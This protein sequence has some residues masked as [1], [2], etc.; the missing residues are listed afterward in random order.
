MIKNISRSLALSAGVT[1]AF[2]LSSAGAWQAS[3]LESQ[4][5][6]D[7]EFAKDA[8]KYQRLVDRYCVSCHNKEMDTAQFVLENEGLSDIKQNG[9]IWEKVIHKLRVGEMPPAEA[10]QPS[11]GAKSALLGW[12]QDTLND[13]AVSNP[14]PGRPSVHRLNRTEYQNAIRDLLDLEIDSKSLLPTDTADFGFDNIGSSL[15]TSPLYLE[16]YMMAASKVSRLAIGDP[17]VKES[18]TKYTIPKLKLQNDRMNEDLSFGSR[19]GTSV[20]HH[21]PLDAD[22]VIKV[23]IESPRSD[24]PQDLFQRSDAP[25]QV[26]VRVDGV[27]VGVFNI[28][29]PKSTEFSYAKGD[30]ADGAPPDE[31][32]L[33]NWFGTRTVEARFTVKAGTRTIAVSFL[34]RTLAYEG[35]RPRTYPAFYDYL[36]ILKNVEPGITDFE[37]LGPYDKFTGEFG[38]VEPKR[39]TKDTSSRNKIFT[40]YP[41]TTADEMPAAKEILGT[42]ARKAYRRPVTDS[43]MDILLDFY[44]QGYE[45]GGFEGG[46][47]F[48]LER[49]L[50]SPSF[51]FRVEADPADMGPSAVYPVSDLDLA[52][53]L[54]FFLW[55]SIPDDELLEIAESGQLRRPD[56]LEAQV[57]RMLADDK[58]EA[59]VKNFAAQ[60]LYLRNLAA[61]TPDVNTFPEFD[62]SLRTALREETERFF[63]NEFRADNNVNELLSANYTFL[64]Q[65]L[66]EHYGIPG[67]YGSHFRRVDLT[68]KNRGGLLG[69][70][71]ILT[72]TSYANRTSPVKRGKWVLENILASPPPSPPTVVPDLPTASEFEEATT[73]RERF[74]QHREDPDC[75][76]CHIKMDPIGFAMENFDAIGRWRTHNAEGLEL[77]TTGQFPDGTMLDGAAGMREVLSGKTE[78][79]RINV[80]QKLLIYGLG[81]GIDYADQP[82]VRQIEKVAIENGS[83]W[84]SIILEIVK[85]TPFQMRRSS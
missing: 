26:D 60:W 83:T 59:M 32:D 45:D 22:Y 9:D 11:D 23:N 31:E 61:V 37:I 65:R 21:F 2:T 72:V 82:A 29:R 70:G 27:R 18:S 64:N 51:L 10:P 14:D 7:T 28:G 53:R 52:S 41:E 69:M 39:M 67:I 1:I 35:V 40:S 84:S 34:K 15:Q 74:E 43:D 58:S 55:S 47:Q 81:R 17:N 75:Y 46:I 73:L 80:I 4:P 38:K 57:R 79:F 25:E 24:Q 16:R 63:E 68:D 42:I 48:G 56:V 62:G 76:A 50:A 44:D 54:S 71:S 66:A 78:E 12:M 36:G 30:F 33:S 49:I 85:S 3:A 19:G 77:D 8:T 6:T 20:R 5:Q 13:H